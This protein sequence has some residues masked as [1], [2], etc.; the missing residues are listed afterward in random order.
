MKARALLGLCRLLLAPAAIT[1]LTGCVSLFDRIADTVLANEV[2]FDDRESPPTA[3]AI[4]A[5]A[6]AIQLL[7]GQGSG[8]GCSLPPGAQVFAFSRHATQAPIALQMRQACAFHDYCYRHGNATYGYSQADCDFLLQQHAFRLCK[9]IN[10]EATISACE[11]NARKV[12]LGVRL[13]GFGSF[14]RAR[15]GDD[16]KA[17]TFFEFDP[18][19][20]RATSFKVVRIADAPARWTHSGVL[21]KAAYHFD[22]RPSGTRVH[23]MGWKTDGRL[24]CAA[25]DLPAS[26]NAINGVPIVVRTKDGQDWF[27]WWQRHDIYSTDGRF[28]LL[29]PGNALPQDWETASGG[30]TDPSARRMRSHVTCF[31][32]RRDDG[33]SIDCI[34][35]KQPGSGLFGTASCAEGQR[36]GNDPAPGPQHEHMRPRP[37][38]PLTVSSR[39]GIR[40][41]RAPA[42]LGDS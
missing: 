21:P 31:R 1:L 13:G 40:H 17:S 9:Y 27:V 10:E 26:Y 42:S 23:V 34:Q 39:R 3:Y 15:S 22:I 12:T 8:L 36:P 29:P 7:G 11:T 28:A 2:R 32:P 25:F 4:P 16:D 19:P 35:D 30:F 41:H 24:A 33:V 5:S 37:D 18:Y 14:R 6:D 38:R 20:V